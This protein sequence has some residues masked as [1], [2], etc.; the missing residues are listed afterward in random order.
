M[1][2][3]AWNSAKL[4][5]WTIRGRQNTDCSRTNDAEHSYLVIVSLGQMKSLLHFELEFKGKIGKIPFVKQFE[6]RKCAGL[7]PP[8]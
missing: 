4:S 5:P 7:L 1:F 6:Q 3:A 8:G 2:R